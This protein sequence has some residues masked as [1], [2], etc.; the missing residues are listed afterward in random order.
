MIKEYNILITGVGGQGVILMSELLGKSAVDDGLRVRGSEVLG[1]AVRGG[2]VVSMVRL[3]DDIEGPLIPAGKG[4]VLVAMEPAEGLRNIGYLSPAGDVILNTRKI[5]PPTVSIGASKYPELADIV[6]KLKAA[7]AR[8]FQ[9]DAAAI[10]QQA[11]SPQTVNIVLLGALFGLGRL[12]VKIET[13]KAAI[14]G[15]FPPKTAP[16]NLKAFDLG[17]QSCH[18]G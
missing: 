16:M 10:A 1:M 14:E 4:D 8:V 7:S 13:M 15:H 17:Y 12:P 11:G 3:G 2:P 9:I 5:I 6:G 18:Q